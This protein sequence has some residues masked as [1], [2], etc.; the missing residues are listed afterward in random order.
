MGAPNLLGKQN[1]SQML[2]IT[3]TLNRVPSQQQLVHTSAI[4]YRGQEQQR[5]AQPNTTTLV[6]APDITKEQHI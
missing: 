3:H 1:G 4:S 2:S 5:N 6:T